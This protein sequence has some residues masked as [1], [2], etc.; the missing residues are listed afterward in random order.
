MAPL[1]G[2]RMAPHTDV[3]LTVMGSPHESDLFT[4][5]LR[6]TQALLETGASVQVWTC[7]YANMMTQRG[8][9]DSKP[10]NLAA[11]SV[12]YPSPAT[13]VRGLLD[14]FPQRLFWFGCRFCSD[15]RGAVDHLPEVALRAPSRFADHV[16][17]ARKTLFI[18][19]M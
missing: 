16:G 8:L 3:L 19:V 4:S 7:G 11:W 9:G 15:D 2:G 14:R 1:A 18:G 17:T 5:V 6:L 10:R 12:D 13:L